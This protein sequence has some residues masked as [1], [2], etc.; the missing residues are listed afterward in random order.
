VHLFA[1]IFLCSHKRPMFCKRPFDF[2]GLE[3][4]ILTLFL[5]LCFCSCVYICA[6]VVWGFRR[7]RAHT[8]TQ[9]L[10][11][12]FGATAGQR[13]F[14]ELLEMRSD[15]DRSSRH[16]LIAKFEDKARALANGGGGGG[17][18]SGGAGGGAGGAGG[19]TSR[20]KSSVASS[21]SADGDDD[22][23]GGDDGN[24]SDND[25]FGGSGKSKKSSKG[26]LFS[27]WS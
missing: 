4:Y 25:F 19:G 1:D 18:G 14:V 20:Q 10:I 9:G 27:F 26:G 7:A 6:R 22:G 3:W 8:H 2:S 17:G 23:D 15:I 5:S 24:D 13:M 11:K 21:S 12:R 16:D